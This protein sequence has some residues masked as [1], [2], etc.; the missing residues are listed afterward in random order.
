M[1]E[2]TTS[3]KNHS[4]TMIIFGGIVVLCSIF[5]VLGMLVGRN[6]GQKI[7]EIAFKEE[8][9]K[10]PAAAPASDEFTLNYQSETTAEK[11]NLELKPAPPAPPEPARPAISSPPAVGGSSSSASTKAPG[12]AR[13]TTTKSTDARTATAKP[14]V[15]RTP[16]KAA[17]EA[18]L[19]ITA[20]RNEKQAQVERKKVESMG[21]NARVITATEKGVQWHRVYVG[22][23]KESQVKLAKADLKAKGYKEVLARW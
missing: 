18:M 21:F 1:E 22:P 8:Q 16:T 15:A 10:K 5:F 17:R 23:Y 3:W 13:A 14:A 2:S 7:A 11:P 4:F 6:Q 12:T 19:Q 20:S 9:A